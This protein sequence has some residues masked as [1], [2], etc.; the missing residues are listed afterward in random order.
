MDILNYYSDDKIAIGVVN[1]KTTSLF[2]D[3]IWVPASLIYSNIWMN[4]YKQI[5]YEVRIIEDIEA[6]I[7]KEGPYSNYF[8]AS[9]RNKGGDT[10]EDTYKYTRNRNE[11][12]L[13]AT[14]RFKTLYG[15]DVTPFFFDYTDF[16]KSFLKLNDTE[17][18]A[19]YWIKNR[20]I[21]KITVDK[22]ASIVE[23]SLSWEQ[24][25]EFKRD[26]NS[27]QKLRRFRNWCT[28][29]LKDKSI[30]EVVE[31]LNQSYDDY[32]FTLKKHGIKTKVGSFTTL[33]STTGTIISML[34]AGNI[35]NIATSLSLSATLLTYTVSKIIDYMDYKN[36]KEPI[37]YIYDV[38][39]E[40]KS[41]DNEI[42]REDPFKGIFRNRDEVNKDL[43]KLNDIF[44]D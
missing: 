40:S 11:A 6:E 37:A 10:I 38:L 12:I 19:E 29:D 28:Y 30:N 27:V 33:L 20:D 3:K 23:K 34:E 31:I 7:F 41:D 39:K 1:P 25:L 2:Y 13:I 35:E 32:C 14:Q 4:E 16:E 15:I 9:M 17:G 22:I 5:P 24:V 8:Y 36:R 26:K 44:K 42:Y 43:Y 21:I 18:K